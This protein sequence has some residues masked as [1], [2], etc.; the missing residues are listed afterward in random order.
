[1]KALK[2]GDWQTNAIEST[3][4]A[5]DTGIQILRINIV[6]TPSFNIDKMLFEVDSTSIIKSAVMDN[7]SAHPNP[8]S[9]FVQ[10][11]GLNISN[12]FT[13][14]IFDLQGKMVLNKIMQS[15]QH[16]NIEKLANGS[17]LFKLQTDKQL[18]SGKLI[19]NK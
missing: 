3:T 7:V 2:T 15:G 8:A 16:L 14:S 19:V 6:S 9:N 10:F 4:F 18:Y 13:V 5:L 11:S 17:Y 1:V 12:N